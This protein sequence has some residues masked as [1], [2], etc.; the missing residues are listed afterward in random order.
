MPYAAENPD[1]MLREQQ[2]ALAVGFALF[3]TWVLWGSTYLAIKI[4]LP[5]FPPFLMMGSRFL[6]AGTL[7][8][9][10]ARA[11]GA[12]VPTRREWRS[13]LVVGTLLLA[14]GAGGT[15]VAERSVASGLAAAFVA[16]EPALIA[17]LSL[18]LGKRPSVSETA[19]ILFG[20]T[21]VVLLVRGS[22]F[23]ASPV[24]VLAMTVA[25][26]S[27][28]LGSILTT[29]K[30]PSAPGAAGAASQMICGGAALLVLSPLAHEAGP[31]WPVTTEAFAAWSYLV[32]FGSMLAFTAFSYLMMHVR[33]SLAMS[34]TFVNPLVALALGS[35]FGDEHFTVSELTAA[36]VITAGV[37]LLL[38]PRRVR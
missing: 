38:V 37:V 35:F 33:T 30:L 8:L 23:S 14:G 7:L 16:F 20:L 26:V 10:T 29:C 32:V 1:E 28:S 19:G 4:A 5:T 9:V 15:A 25:I 34:Y 11:R 24:G 21:G 6:V 12:P 22:G 36:A 13:A 18:P 3:A 27:W 17:L 2:H 31:R